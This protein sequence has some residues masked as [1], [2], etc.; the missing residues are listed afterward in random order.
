MG[1]EAEEA[2]ETPIP[3]GLM[4]HSP[5]SHEGLPKEM[6]WFGHPVA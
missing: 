1:Q 2:E 6:A 4:L 5:Q 3:P